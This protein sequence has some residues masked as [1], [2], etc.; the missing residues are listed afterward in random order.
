MMS[1]KDFQK[2][3]DPNKVG[4]TTNNVFGLPFTLA[5]AALVFIPVP[6]DVT[7][8][9]FAGTSKG[10][11][12]ILK[13]SYQI[14]LFAPA[15]TDAWKHG[16]AFE[17]IDPQLVEKNRNLRREAEAY[18]RFLEEGG[19]VDKDNN[20]TLKLNQ[21]NKGCESLAKE[22]KEKAL[23]YLNQKKI[24]FLVGGD[25]SISSGLIGA[26]AED[27]EFGVLQIDAHADLRSNYMGFTHSHASVMHRALKTKSVQK[28]IQVGIREICP[29]EQDVINQ[30]PNKIHTYFDHMLH[31][32]LYR[33]VNWETICNQIAEKL[34][35]KVYI[36]FDV[37][38]L[39]P[40][41]CPGTGTP[42]PGGL[43]YNQAV[44]LIEKVM[45]SN[46]HIIGADLVETGPS[47]L[48]GIVSSRLLFQIASM[49]IQSNKNR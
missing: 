2:R 32:D 4:V 45:Q 23:S 6:W 21:I 25:H 24:P 43:S 12:N 8:S 29:E 26:L 37:D 17:E 33:G 31:R 42:V 27:N 49:M 19:D 47:T 16:M 1:I 3:Y 22:T 46:K 39:Q 13:N 11:E 14:D 7:T 5:E 20:M 34:P 38:G 10:P 41:C 35:E 28:I 36:T 15:A 48:D 44:F 9:N 30:H 18:I 40:S